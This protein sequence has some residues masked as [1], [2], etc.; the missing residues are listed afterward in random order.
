MIN[1]LLP[2]QPC[3]QANIALISLISKQRYHQADGT[4][5]PLSTD[6]SISRS[7][8]SARGESCLADELCKVISKAQSL[9]I[10]QQFAK[11]LQRNILTDLFKA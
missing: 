4:V 11:C 2:K 1:G 7:R 6:T 5:E 8:E 3:F 10:K 9:Y